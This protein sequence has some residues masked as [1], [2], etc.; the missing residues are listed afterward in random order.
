MDKRWIVLVGLVA[1]AL[2]G[3]TSIVVM[4]DPKTGAMAQCTGDPDWMFTPMIIDRCAADYEK[5][6]WVR[7]SD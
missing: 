6:G 5:A 3:C 2:T 1:V 7:M 4:R